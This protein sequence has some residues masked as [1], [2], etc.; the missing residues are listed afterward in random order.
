MNRALALVAGV[1]SLAVARGD[2]TEST[3][4]GTSGL[5]DLAQVSGKYMGTAADTDISDSYCLTELENLSDFGMIT[6][7]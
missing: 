4:T 7:G 5:N 3:Y 6:P 1:S 2:I